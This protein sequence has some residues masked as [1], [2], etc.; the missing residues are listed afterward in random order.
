MCE[1][2]FRRGATSYTAPAGM[3][4]DMHTMP[5]DGRSDVAGTGAAISR[6]VFFVF[7][8]KA[9]ELSTVALPIK[10][11]NLGCNYQTFWFVAAIDQVPKK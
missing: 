2:M 1:D 11:E 6:L 8:A 3:H 4:T 9:Y 5:I 7:Y 10:A